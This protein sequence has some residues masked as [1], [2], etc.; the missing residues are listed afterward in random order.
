M[1]SEIVSENNEYAMCMLVYVPR[2]STSGIYFFLN[3]EIDNEAGSEYPRNF[4]LHRRVG[5][6][7]R[8]R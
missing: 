6:P 7:R 5:D 8:E 1:K 4:Q 2:E 3:S